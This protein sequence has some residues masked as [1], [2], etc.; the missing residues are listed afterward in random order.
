VQFLQVYIKRKKRREKNKNKKKKKKKNFLMPVKNLY[1]RDT[2]LIYH[3]IAR[4]LSLK[5]I[6]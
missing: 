3:K 1:D 2:S 5:V 4:K 6:S